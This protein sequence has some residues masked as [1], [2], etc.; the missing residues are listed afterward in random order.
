ML[1]LHIEATTLDQ[2]R[3]QALA[4]LGLDMAIAAEIQAAAPTR[5]KRATKA[6]PQVA[7]PAPAGTLAEVPSAGQ[8]APAGSAPSID[9]NAEFAKYQ[10]AV[11]LKEA[12]KEIDPPGTPTLQQAREAVL[13]YMAKNGET[14]DKAPKVLKLLEKYSAKLIPDILAAHRAAFIAEC[15]K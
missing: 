9:H 6:E 15:D 11:D 13:R 14:V 4:Q 7:T 10:A 8:P 2:L 5:V 12:A 3:A 1:T